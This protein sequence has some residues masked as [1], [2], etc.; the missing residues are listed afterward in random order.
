MKQTHH[1]DENIHRI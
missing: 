1:H